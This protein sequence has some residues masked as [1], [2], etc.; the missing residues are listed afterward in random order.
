M[1][2]VKS[3]NEA[4]ALRIFR[5]L[6]S[7]HRAELLSLVHLACFAENS[8]RKSLGF[9]PVIDHAFPIKPQE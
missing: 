7:E 9:E 8:V 4:E 5:L 2:I 3:S 1:E 6:K